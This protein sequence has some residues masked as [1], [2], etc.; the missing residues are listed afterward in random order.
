MEKLK[1]GESYICGDFRIMI[2]DE[3]ITIHNIG[4][5]AITIMP[6]SENKILIT[7]SKY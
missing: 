7:K 3:T 2:S 1:C 6:I 5:G 4:S